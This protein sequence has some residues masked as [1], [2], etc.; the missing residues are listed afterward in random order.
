MNEINQQTKDE[1]IAQAVQQGQTEF[2]G[3]LVT[4]YEKAMLRYGYKFLSQRQDI[5]DLVQ[6]VFL[7]AY[8]NIQSFD[9]ERKFSSWLYRIAHN[10]FINALKKKDKQPLLFFDADT[11]FPHPIAK[12]KTDKLIDEK[13]I[14]AMLDKCLQQVSIKYREPLVLYYLEELSYQE[15]S[16]ILQI[17]ISTVGVRIKR[18]KEKIKSLCKDEKYEV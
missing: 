18:G 2:F 14:K 1:E 7:K 13:Q 6:D 3:L 15:I 5:E 17:P 4:K 9:V 10:T 12:E 11:L 16:D 8:T